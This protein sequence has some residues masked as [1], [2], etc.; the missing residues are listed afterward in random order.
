MRT[1]LNKSKRKNIQILGLTASLARNPDNLNYEIDELCQMLD[2]PVLTPLSC[3]IELQKFSPRPAELA[4]MYK[5]SIGVILILIYLF[6]SISIFCF[7]FF[8]L[9]K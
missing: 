9:C 6:F 3:S 2:S 7:I 1:H 5:E 4:V 8:F